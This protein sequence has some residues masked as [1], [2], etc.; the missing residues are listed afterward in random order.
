[1]YL[2]WIQS[3]IYGLV[4]GM[5]EILPVSSAAHK[6]LLLKFYG[7]SSGM[8]LMDLLIRLGIV[9]ALYISCRSQIV[10]LA[11]ARA[12]ARVPKRRR[13]RPLDEK[14]LMDF[15]L[16]RTML[17]PVILGL[18]VYRAT[19]GLSSSLMVI[20]V[21]LFLNGLALYVPQFLPTGNRDSRTLS[22]VEG[23]LMGL[24]GGASILP[25]LSAMGLT[26]SVASVCGVE[27]SYAL[28]MALLMNLGM[29]VGWVV[30]D[31]I[32]LSSAQAALSAGVLIRCLASA[33][34]AFGGALL[35]VRLMRRLAAEHGNAVFGFYC[36][37]VALLLFILN[38]LA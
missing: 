30:Q 15:S 20:A 7:V 32:T 9:A 31:M 36:M 21:L 29:N 35:C 10:R 6:A 23:L 14:S 13:R 8:E 28:N 4:A 18:L 3:L 33:L 12:L 38:L 17:V 1:M 37:G 24:G 34:V 19:M 26:T 16:L 11:R 5:T 2:D 22:R 27:R 25:G